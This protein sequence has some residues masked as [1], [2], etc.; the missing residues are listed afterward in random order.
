LPRILRVSR[1]TARAET[2]ANQTVAQ[3]TGFI[4]WT[5]NGHRLGCYGACAHR[6]TASIVM[7]LHGCTGDPIDPSFLDD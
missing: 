7:F 2:P 5:Y 3:Q 4:T 1:T 6:Q